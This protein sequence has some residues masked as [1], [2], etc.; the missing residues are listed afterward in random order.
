MIL[1]CYDGSEDARAAVGHAGALFP[2][3]A[4][5]V[6]TVWQPFIQTVAQSA[7][8]FGMAAAV[9]DSEAIDGASL[10]R[11]QQIAHDGAEVANRDGLEAVPRACAEVSTTARTILGEAEKVD[12]DAIVMGSRGLTGLKSLLLGGVSHEV[13]QHADRTVVV[14]PSPRVAASR[15][16]KVQ[17]DAVAIG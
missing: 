10:R 7:L 12:A 1:I 11:A 17:E 15:A 3:Q 16:R 14:V 6:L 5:I 8:G 9:E 4:A 2:G 13:I